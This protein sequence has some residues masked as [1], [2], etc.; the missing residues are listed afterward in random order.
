[1][2][3]ATVAPFQ[4]IGISVRTTNENNQAAKDIEVLWQRFMQEQ[5]LAN[6][7]NKVDDTVYAVYTD[8][9]SDHTKPYTTFIG[10]KVTTANEIPEGMSSII[11]GG[12]DYA[13]SSVRGNL[14]EGFVVKEWMR[15]WNSDLD[16]AYTADFEVYAPNEKDL[17]NL[18]VGFYIAVN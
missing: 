8:Y 1:M 12:G 9:E 6:I 17:T 16:R 2:Q 13:T 7:P 11:I 14:S 3:N 4:L 10:C 5:C 18:E 15:I